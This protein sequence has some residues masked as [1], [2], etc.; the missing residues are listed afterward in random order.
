M[1]QNDKKPKF[2]ILTQ[3]KFLNLRKIKLWWIFITLSLE[4]MAQIEML[5]YSQ[6][7]AR[8]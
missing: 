4:Y 5:G 6:V 2:C 1:L 3:N 7:A 8:D